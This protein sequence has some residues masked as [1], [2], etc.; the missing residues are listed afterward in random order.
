VG[1]EAFGRG[2]LCPEFG[3]MVR[4]WEAEEDKK[5]QKHKTVAGKQ[6]YDQD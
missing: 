4:I 1:R 6:S 3:E 5:Y 2:G